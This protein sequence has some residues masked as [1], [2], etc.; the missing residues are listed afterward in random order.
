MKCFRPLAGIK[1]IAHKEDC[2]LQAE[3]FPSPRGDKENPGFIT[4]THLIMGFRPLAG[5]K[6]ILVYLIRLLD[7]KVSVPSRG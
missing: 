2:A 3:R 6:K 5:I 4:V 1:K 7:E